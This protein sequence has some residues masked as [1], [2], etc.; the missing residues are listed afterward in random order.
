MAWLGVL[1]LHISALT[2]H[3]STGR[4]FCLKPTKRR[5]RDPSRLLVRSWQCAKSFV[6]RRCHCQ[7]TT[8][9]S[10]IHYT[11]SVSDVYVHTHIN[12]HSSATS[13]ITLSDE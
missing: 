1:P 3:I 11:S 5:L 4:G 2:A 13:P 10:Y 12:A 6:A 8:A 7:L 9:H